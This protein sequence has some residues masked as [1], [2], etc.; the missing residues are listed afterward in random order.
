MTLDWSIITDVAVGY[1]IAKLLR[2]LLIEG[3]LKPLARTAGQTLW[4]QLD[5]RLG[6]RLPNWLP[7]PPHQLKP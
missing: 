3:L 7:H 2:L 1:A 5:A 6:D 4:Y